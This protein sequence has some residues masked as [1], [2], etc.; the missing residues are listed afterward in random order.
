MTEKLSTG[1]NWTKW[2]HRFHK[3]LIDEKSLLPNKSTLLIAVSGGQDSMALLSTFIK[4]RELHQWSIFVWHG[5]HNWQKNS[6]ITE[7]NLMR[8]CKLRQLNFLSDKAEI[9]SIKSEEK[10][11]EWRYSK[12][13]ENANRL[14][15]NHVITAHTG[16]DRA[17]TLILNLARGAN[18]KGLGSLSKKRMLAKNIYLIRPFLIFSRNET[19][20]ICKSLK[21]PF[22][23]D[24]SNLDQRFARNKIRESI[25]P[26]MEE[27][28]P[29]SSSR[30]ANLAERIENID[31]E[32]AE[33]VNLS[34]QLLFNN[35]NLERNKFLHLSK[36]TRASIMRQYL[37]DKD[38]KNLSAKIINK[39]NNNIENNEIG[40]F[41]LSNNFIIQ[42]GKNIISLRCIKSS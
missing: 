42:W 27:L 13:I 23:P 14:S 26:I 10:A 39:L 25:V 22:W 15:C 5:N 21:I 35:N 29:G 11:R 30:I 33:L 38:V 28:Y 1:K 34:I 12:L 7:T 4:L 36:E 9:N 19:L 24:P 3:S 20:E 2:E 41:Q 17:E 18:F 8:W 6:H 32:H 31:K 40:N 37:L 16:S